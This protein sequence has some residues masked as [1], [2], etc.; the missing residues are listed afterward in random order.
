MFKKLDLR[1]L[2]IRGIRRIAREKGGIS[3]KLTHL[4][5]L[6][7]Q[8]YFSGGVD[9]AEN[10]EG[11][12]INCLKSFKPSC[13]FDVGAHS[14]V[15]SSMACKQFPDAT[16]HAFE[17][18]R[19]TYEVLKHNVSSDR[20]RTNN[21]GLSNYSGVAIY[22]DYAEGGRSKCNTLIG[23]HDLWDGVVPHSKRKCAITTGDSY[24][25]AADIASIDILKIDTE[26]SEYLVLSGFDDMITSKK[27]RV[28]QF[29]YGYSTADAGQSM[30][31]FFSFFNK[32]GY[33]VGKLWSDGVEFT[34]FFYWLNN[35]DSGPNF[36]AVRADDTDMQKAISIKRQP[37]F[38]YFQQDA[39]F[40]PVAASNEQ[41]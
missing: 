19:S 11:Y 27:V 22:K 41:E 12:L 40:L 6:Y 20:V 38:A 23:S 26:G 34:E 2:I 24:C 13:I 5:Q 8:F 18:S 36:V 31:D 32:R 37:T 16:I 15:W 28:V 17:I 1:K 25:K 29:E 4:A 9:F 30:K 35:Y 3:R 39:A 7:L 21:L 14:G 10:G 33:T